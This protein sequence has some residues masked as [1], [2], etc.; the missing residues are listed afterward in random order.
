MMKSLK[1]FAAAAAIVAMASSS[2]MATPST[3]IWIPSTD[4]QAFK[5]VHLG[6]DNYV[7]TDRKSDGTRDPNV[8]DV[9]LTAGVL[10]FEKVQMEVGIDYLVNGTSYDNY[11]LYFNA[12]LGTPENSLFKH[13]PALAIG[14]YNFGTN[15][16]TGSALRTDQNIAY[17]LVAK[18]IPVAGRISAGYFVGNSNVL[19][20]ENGK[21]ENNG[22]LLSWDRTI[23]EISDNLWAAVDYQGSDS[24]MGALSFGVAWSFSKNVSVIF[25]YDVY[26]N[27]NIAGKNT[28]TTQLDI[29]F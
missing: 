16:T 18:T 11:P 22:V 13:S 15:S 9:G 12:K 25:G 21:K 24:A 27:R 17:A 29:N 20:D 28:F 14:G 2:A 6:I 1:M 23:S 10:P 5:S 3:Q 8:Y 19:L 26:N 7:R 4:V